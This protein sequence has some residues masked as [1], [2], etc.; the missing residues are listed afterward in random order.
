M[1]AIMKLMKNNALSSNMNEL[2][3]RYNPEI[4]KITE[5]MNIKTYPTFKRF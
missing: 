5:D 3:L 1:N 4:N 2:G